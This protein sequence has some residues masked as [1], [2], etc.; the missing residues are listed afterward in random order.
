MRIF[1]LL[2]ILTLI[3]TT[4]LFAQYETVLLNYEK[5]YFGENQPL[6]ASKYFIVNG[7]IR[8]DVQYVEL[9][10]YKAKGKD[11]R[12]PLSS[13]FWKRD[14]NNSAPTFNLPVNYKLKEGRDY[15]YLFSFYRTVTSKER[16]KL[17]LNIYETL[18]AYVNQSFNFSNRKL[19]LMR[20]HRQTINDLNQI[21]E[22]GM[23][24]YRSRTQATF[25]GFSDMIKLK[26]E[27]VESVKLK[28]AE[29]LEMAT[30]ST[31]ARVALRNQ[32]IGEL[33][34]MLHQ[35]VAPYLNAEIYVLLDDKY[36]DNY[37]TEVVR[38]AYYLAPHFG[39]GGVGI[40]LNKDD[41]AYASNMY[42]G[43]SVPL[44]KASKSNFWSNTA[45]SFG[46][47]LGNFKDKKNNTEISGPF[48]KVPTYVALGY[49]PFGFF[50]VQAGAAFLENVTPAGGGTIPGFDKKVEVRPFIGVSAELSLW[51]N[52]N[53]N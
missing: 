12:K 19:K 22:R 18:D 29:R 9:D 39:Y 50:R 17:T 1:T 35:E 53:K 28:K 38:D 51:F 34:R 2:T 52:F 20:N 41:F 24:L 8:S 31:G 25:P 11:N 4:S 15:D 5:S 48:F 33:K 7:A 30:D 44:G 42:V 32:L 45:V 3:T 13:S 6:P 26:L 27:Q 14:F 43:M 23:S 46:A 21:V 37:P 49:R 47:F 40:N 10:I 16:A 36:I